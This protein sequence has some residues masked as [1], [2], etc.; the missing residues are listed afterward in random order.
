MEEIRRFLRYIQT[1]EK[2]CPYFSSSCKVMRSKCRYDGKLISSLCCVG[3][4][5]LQYMFPIQVIERIVNMKRKV[6]Q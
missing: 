4:F 2:D 1:G 3:D 6:K 5:C